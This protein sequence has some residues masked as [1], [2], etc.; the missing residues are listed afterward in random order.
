MS[1][2]PQLRRL[3]L[4]RNKLA[5]FHSESLPESN[6][7]QDYNSV[8]FPYLEELNFSFNIVSEE[9]G[10]LYCATQLPKMRLIDIT[11]NPFAITGSSDECYASLNQVMEARGAIIVNETLER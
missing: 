7:T 8:A 3:N 2:I 6:L 9:E 1:T 11:G 4:S 10:L 5:E